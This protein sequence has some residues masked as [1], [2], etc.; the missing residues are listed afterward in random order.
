M[1]L[2]GCLREEEKEK[3]I[4]CGIFISKKDFIFLM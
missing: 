1:V 3:L 2:S 4:L